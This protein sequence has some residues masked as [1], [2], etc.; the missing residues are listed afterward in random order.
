VNLKINIQYAVSRRD[1]PTPRVFRRWAKAAYGAQ[2]GSAEVVIR[3]V[4]LEEG[5][6]LNETYRKGRGPTNVLS[7]PYE[8]PCWSDPP[9]LGDLVICA[10][11]VFAEVEEQGK[12]PESHWAHLVVHGML[13]LQGYDHQNEQE[14]EIMERFEALTLRRLGFPAPLP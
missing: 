1:L 2:Y 10:P 5:T 7:F 13:H 8:G 14:A 3:V 11:V 6:S 4:D 12:E 9:L